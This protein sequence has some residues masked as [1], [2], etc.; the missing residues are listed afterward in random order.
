MERLGRQRAR[1]TFSCCDTIFKFQLSSTDPAD[2]GAFTVLPP[3]FL[4]SSMFN[5]ALIR[6]RPII[7]YP[8]SFIYTDSV[9]SAYYTNLR[10]QILQSDPGGSYSGNVAGNGISVMSLTMSLIDDPL[11]A[12]I[13]GKPIIA[14]KVIKRRQVGSP[15]K[16]MFDPLRAFWS[17]WLS[18]TVR[19][20]TSRQ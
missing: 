11:S 20:T 13:R 2:L 9:F 14:W 5:R 18:F 19:C 16:R 10:S 12:T 6:F 17:D 7:E 1:W 8:S 15:S 4:L 3:R